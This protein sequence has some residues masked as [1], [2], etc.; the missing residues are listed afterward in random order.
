M[1]IEVQSKKGLR[2]VLSVAVDKKTIQSK[3]DERLSELP[4]YE[5]FK[6][7]TKSDIADI[8]ND[9]FGCRA[10]TL[11]G[12]AFLWNFIDEKTD[13]CH[14]DIAGPS[15]AID[16]TTGYGVRLITSYLEKN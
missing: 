6:N 15:R 1:K 10:S 16:S 11:H 12:G 2:T 5:E 3:M 14:L 9:E 7:Q 13:W 4:L 8:K